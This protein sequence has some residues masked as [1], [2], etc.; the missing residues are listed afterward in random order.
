MGVVSLA[1]FDEGHLSQDE[2]IC[3]KLPIFGGFHLKVLTGAKCRE[4][5]GMGVAGIVMND[6][7]M[8]Q[9]PSFPTFS[10]SKTELPRVAGTNW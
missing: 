8:N 3:D 6:Y 9:Q 4:W 1:I 5:M 2:A 7:G 10:T